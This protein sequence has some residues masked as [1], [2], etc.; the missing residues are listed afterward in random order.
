MKANA[1]SNYVPQ[2]RTYYIGADEVRLELRAD[3]AR[4]RSPAS[5][6]TRSRHLFVK[7]GPRPDR[8]TYLKCALPRVHRRVV[9]APCKQRAAGEQH[10][11]LLGPVIRAEVG[12]T[13]KVVFRNN[14]RR[15]PSS[16][17]PHGVF[18]DKDS[19]GAPYNDG[20]QRRRQSR[21]RRAAGQHAT[22]TPGR[23]PSAPARARAT[24][25][26]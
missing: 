18:Y 24:A 19:E 3:R 16:V 9:H 2:T 11:G 25:A 1:A 4:T 6:S 22:P 13:I 21:R 7:Q 23:C 20:T 8:L 14:L 10:L 12:D 5:R 26:R 17:H 15:S